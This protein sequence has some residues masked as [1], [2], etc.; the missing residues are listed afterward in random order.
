MITLKEFFE[1]VKYRITEGSNY[2]WDCFGPNSYCFDSWNGDQDGF[3]ISIVF[4]TVS[5]IAY[6]VEAFDYSHERAYRMINPDFKLA[7]NEE[8]ANRGIVDMA[9]EKD[10]GSPVDYT[11]LESDD[12]WIQKALAIVAGEEYDTRVTVPLNL[13]DDELF[14]LMKLAHERDITLNALVAEIMQL[15]IDREKA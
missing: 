14:R 2:E 13:S 7:F 8:T 3:T 9:W 15:T 4:D 10:D 11:D 6:K 12:D 5:Q 1:I